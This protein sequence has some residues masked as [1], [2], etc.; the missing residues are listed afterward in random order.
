M[1]M[2]KP[3]IHGFMFRKPLLKWYFSDDSSLYTS[4]VAMKQIPG[5][6]L[7]V[8]QWIAMNLSVFTSHPGMSKEAFSNMLKVQKRLVSNCEYLPSSYREATAMVKDYTIDKVTFHVCPNDCIMYRNS[9]KY[10]YAHLTMCPTCSENRYKNEKNKIPRRTFHYIPIGQRLARIYREENLCKI[11]QSHPGS[12]NEVLQKNNQMWDK[13]KEVYAESGYFRGDKLGLSFALEVDGVNPYHNIG[14]IYSMT[15]MMM[16][17]LNLPRQVRNCFKNIMLVGI[18]KG[19]KNH[20]DSNIDAYVEILVDELLSLT[21]CTMY[22]AY[23]KAPVDVKLKLLLYVLDY[24]GLSK[25][26][27]QHGSGSLLGCHW[28]N[29]NGFHCAQLQKVVYLSN[30]SYLQKDNPIRFDVTNFCE[31]KVDNTCKPELR[32]IEKEKEY[33]EA[34]E[35]AQNKTQAKAV[36]KATG[37][38]GKYPLQKLTD[39][40]RPEECV[41]DACHTIKDVIQ[42]IIHR[43]SRKNVN[44]ERLASAEQHYERFSN[45]TGTPLD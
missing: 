33:R 29:V 40:N 23:S 42:N 16:T 38:K 4:G 3:N 30:R 9:D 19:K 28:C 45:F 20:S 8:L 14:V 12:T 26:F 25:L 43:I 10:K 2:K 27:H 32:S 37:C 6:D 7:T 22:S 44:K 31:K 39:H 18:I 41:P 5:Y 11:V 1:G 24:P 34:F 36:S 15:P 13:W 21:G 35:S 17:I